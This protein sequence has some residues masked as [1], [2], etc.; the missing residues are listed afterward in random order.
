MIQT[1][2]PRIEVHF[3][4]ANDNAKLDLGE[5]VGYRIGLPWNFAKD[6]DFNLI[7]EPYFERY[8]FGRSATSTLTSNGAPVGTVFEPRS[9]TVNY[10]LTVGISTFF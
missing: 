2:S 5:R 9:E 4:N 7:L 3:N 6:K 1:I 8:E 10:G